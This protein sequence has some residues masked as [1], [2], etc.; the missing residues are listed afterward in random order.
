[1]YLNDACNNFL[2]EVAPFVSEIS[3]SRRS[4]FVTL[5]HSVDSEE[6]ALK[7]YYDKEQF[8]H[9]ID[10]YV[11]EMLST[12]KNSK[13]L[14]DAGWDIHNFIVDRFNVACDYFG[15][16]IYLIVKTF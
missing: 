16:V 5:D 2:Q 9:L 15:D 1:M 6:F 14:Y 11:N 10:Q 13:K 4:R 3:F 12:L 8:D 7:I